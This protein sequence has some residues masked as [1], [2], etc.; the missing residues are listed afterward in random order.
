MGASISAIINSVIGI[1]QT[2]LGIVLSVCLGFGIITGP[3]TAEPI[4]FENS[5]ECLMSFV[6]LADTHVRETKINT[7]YLEC[8]FNDM[9]N[10]DEEFDAVVIAGDLTEFGDGISYEA[11]WDKL[12]ASI[13]AEKA[14]LLASGNHDIRIAYEYQTEMIMNKASEY[15][16]MEIDKPYYSYDVEGYTFVVLGSDKWQLE[17]AVISDEQLNFLD[18]ELARATKD[19]KPAF[20]ICHQPLSDT[21]GLPEVWKNGDMGEDSAAVREILTKYQNVFYI[22][23]HLHDG[24]YEKSLEVLDEA[25]GVYSINLPAYGRENDY[26]EFRQPGLGDF[27]EVY[28]DRVVFTARDFRAGENLEGMTY[29]FDLK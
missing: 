24:V 1:V 28:A 29:T 15:L 18:S 23:G 16:D 12:D 14:I 10:T 3:S 9:A 27:V 11:L 4:E 5:E 17:K 8:G 26:G 25:K 21:H 7:Y 13:F 22:N 6:A 19:G 20:V 2:F